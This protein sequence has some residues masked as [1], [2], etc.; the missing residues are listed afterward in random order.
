MAQVK[1]IGERLSAVENELQHHR[2]EI[3]QLRQIAQTMQKY[4]A[5]QEERNELRREQLR[6]RL[7]TEAEDRKRKH[8]DR[9][10]VWARWLINPGIPVSAVLYFAWSALK[11][12]G[13]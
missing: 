11:A 10:Q 3:S 7:A 4:V 5:A 8:A 1:P 13:N 9:W 2:D 6:C 12:T